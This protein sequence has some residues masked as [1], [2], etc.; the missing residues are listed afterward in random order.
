LN[1]LLLVCGY[2]HRLLHSSDWEVAIVNGRPE[3]CPPPFLDPARNPLIN[4]LHH[5]LE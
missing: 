2:H 5:R 1:N 3:F 4:H